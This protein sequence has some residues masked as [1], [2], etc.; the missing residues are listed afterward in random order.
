MHLGAGVI[1]RRDAQKIVVL[2]G[3]VMDGL[4]AGGLHQRRVVVQD[5]LG[6]A[7]RSGGEIDGC[8]VRIFHQHQ[9]RGGGDIGNLPVIVL[10]VGR[11][12]IT[13]KVEQDVVFQLGDDVFDSAN[14]LRAIEEHV[15]VRGLQAVVDLLTREAEI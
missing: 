7:G 10:R 9:G 2:G 13:H 6:E 8:V 1:E 5:G 3:L 11:T 12:L 4:H 14:E 15:G